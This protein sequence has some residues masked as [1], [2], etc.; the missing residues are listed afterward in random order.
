MIVALLLLPGTPPPVE[1][2]EVPLVQ[3]VEGD[4]AAGAAGGRAGGSTSAASGAA[5]E[6]PQETT[7]EPVP[8]PVAL[9]RPPRPRPA[10]RVTQTPP[11]PQSIPTPAPQSMAVPLPPAPQPGTAATG[12]SGAGP[13]SATGTG[14]G[15]TGAGAG[16]FGSGQGPGD[17]YLERLR[18][19]LAKHRRY[20][21]EA[22]RQKQEGTVQVEFTLARDGTVLAARIEKSAGYPLLDQAVLD[23]LRSASPVP[24]LPER[25]TGDRIRISLPIGFSLGFFTKLF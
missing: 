20:P 21:P 9:P 7:P 22:T 17:E 15:V 2:I 6:A 5:A 14:Q 23:M 19:H 13:G 1:E 8:A 3:L 24:P 11:P 10:P 25:F 16:A 18:R 4:G 12:L